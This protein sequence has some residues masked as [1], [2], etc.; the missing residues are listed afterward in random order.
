MYD[1]AIQDTGTFFTIYKDREIEAFNKLNYLPNTFGLIPFS[2]EISFTN[3]VDNKTIL[4][5]SIKLIKLLLTNKFTDKYIIFYDLE[6]FKQS[7][8]VKYLKEE[9][10]NHKD[11]IIRSRT[12]IKPSSD[13]KV[14]AGLLINP[15]EDNCKFLKHYLFDDGKIIDSILDENYESDLIYLNDTT[16]ILIN[17]EI[18]DNIEKE[19]RCFIVDNKIIDI[20][21]Y[22]EKGSLNSKVLEEVEYNEVYDYIT[23]INK[24]FKPHDHY[25]IDVCKVNGVFKVVEY[26][27]INCSGYY[28]I[29]LYKLFKTLLEIGE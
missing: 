11:K 22:Y 13:L 8:Y 28:D 26:N 18:I 25:V 5:G 17:E 1:I 12:F 29:D 6:K 16:E 24:L 23:F 9:L 27:C 10:L 2:N 14:F 21:Q 3:E 15:I 7:Y 4:L 19:Y 20:C